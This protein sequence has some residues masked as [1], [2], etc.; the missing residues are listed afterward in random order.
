MKK[1][2]QNFMT[3]LKQATQ[4][5]PHSKTPLFFFFLIENE[6]YENGSNKI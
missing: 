4:A 2:Q 1:I 6:Q 3:T 5:T